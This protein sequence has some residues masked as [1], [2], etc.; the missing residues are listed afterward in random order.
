M[1]SISAFCFLSYS[2]HAALILDQNRVIFPASETQV[3]IVKVDNPTGN[4]FL[5]QSWVEDKDGRAQEN[6]FVDPPLSKIKSHHKVALRITTI[7][8]QIADKN[9]EQLYWLNVKEIPKLETDSTQ[10]RL[11]IVMRTRVKVLYRPK[12]VPAR[13][14][15]EYSQVEWHH[16][17]SGLV[18][19]NPTPHY[20]TFNKVWSGSSKD[21]FFDVDMIAP[22]SDLTVSSKAAASAKLVSFNI[23]DDFGD[24]SDTVTAKVK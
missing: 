9:E 6:I 12:S 7:N 10:P 19:H 4:D 2:A 11:A 5:M 17:G 23:I 1:L 16:T 21:I 3:A 14:H 13:M 22:N 8:S 24:T 15:K 18:I 20:I